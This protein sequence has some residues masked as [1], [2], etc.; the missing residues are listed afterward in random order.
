MVTEGIKRKRSFDCL[1]LDS[2]EVACGW[3]V[4]DE[5]FAGGDSVDGS[6]LLNRLQRFLRAVSLESGQYVEPAWYDV[7]LCEVGEAPQSLKYASK[8]AFDLHESESYGIL[9]L[10]VAA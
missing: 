4:R 8:C 9:V 5:G 1:S 3:I 6:D 2:L 10:K 7:G